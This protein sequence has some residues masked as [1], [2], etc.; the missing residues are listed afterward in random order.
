MHLNLQCPASP[1]LLMFEP[2]NRLLAI[3]HLP[4]NPQGLQKLQMQRQGNQ[5]YLPF[6]I[7][8]EGLID[9][10]QQQFRQNCGYVE[11][12]RLRQIHALQGKTAKKYRT[13]RDPV[14]YPT[15]Q[16]MYEHLP[17]HAYCF[18]RYSKEYSAMP[19]HGATLI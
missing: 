19:Q 11:L 3:D 1:T 5:R 17:T 10:R 4:H 9:P 8:F 15:I 2:P 13:P 16:L 12:V 6:S 14:H 7:Q 18:C